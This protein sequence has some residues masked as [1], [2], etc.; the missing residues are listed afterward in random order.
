MRELSIGKSGYP[1]VAFLRDEAG[2]LPD[3]DERRIAF[4]RRILSHRATVL[5]FAL[6]LAARLPNREEVALEIVQECYLRAL[7]YFSSF[8]GHD[9]VGWLRKITL[10]TFLTWETRE[11]SLNLTFVGL[12][13]GVASGWIEPLWYVECKDPEWSVI[14]KV[15][16][17]RLSLLIRELP[18]SLRTV[19]VLREIEGLTYNEIAVAVGVP[20]GTVMS[21]LARARTILRQMWL[22]R[23]AVRSEQMPQTSRVVAA[24][25]R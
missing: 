5:A 24:I 8:A 2:L 13:I 6:R 25:R 21:R 3:H 4:E 1:C 11:R 12:R 19:L 10:N 16:S 18:I 7:Q 22:A 14:T 23:H 17:K 20:I 9:V 15:D